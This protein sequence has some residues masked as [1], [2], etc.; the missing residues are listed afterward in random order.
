MARGQF[1]TPSAIDLSL[2]VLV[3]AG[4]LPEAMRQVG[5]ARRLLEVGGRD[6]FS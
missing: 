3:H 1:K 2:L 4:I 6:Y 5:E